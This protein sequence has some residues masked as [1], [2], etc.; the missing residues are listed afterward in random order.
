MAD[1]RPHPL[2]TEVAAGL[3]A[4]DVP[5]ESAKPAE[6][7]AA[8]DVGTPVAATTG[9]LGKL[10]KTGVGKVVGLVKSSDV[11][12][13]VTFAGYLGPIVQ[14]QNKDWCVLF[15]DTRL[16]SALL[17][18]KDGIVYR[19]PVK[20]DESPCGIRDVLWVTADTRVVVVSASQSL[21]SQFLTGEFTRAG[22]FDDTPRGG[23]TMAAATGVFC[24]A[25]TVG[26]C[27]RYSVVGT[28]KPRYC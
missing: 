19:D 18:Q 26:C 10:S 5:L 21:E 8:V 7:E 25:R 22:D 9:E 17:V 20:S 24:E 23:G 1:L 12:E 15:L 4:A 3:V 14:R 6:V 28:T 11:P 2:I 16:D 27:T 13:L